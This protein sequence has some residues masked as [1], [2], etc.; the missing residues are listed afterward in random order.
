MKLT[1][2]LSVIGIATTTLALPTMVD[3]HANT[4]ALS[5][6]SRAN[7]EV[8]SKLK[9]RSEEASQTNRAALDST[10]SRA[11]WEVWS[12]R[13]EPSSAEARAAWESWQKRA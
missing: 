4:D 9:A 7:W 2:L 11:N 1:T 12:K 3:I 10:E 6:E 13:A 5:A 8:W